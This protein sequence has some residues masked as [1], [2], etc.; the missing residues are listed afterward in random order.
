[1]LINDK[2]DIEALVNACLDSYGIDR[3]YSPLILQ[4]LRDCTNLTHDQ[5]KQAALE[6]TAQLTSNNTTVATN[7]PSADQRLYESSH[8]YPNV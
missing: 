8:H 3:R 7:F 6:L 2:D 1:M 4:E 5:L